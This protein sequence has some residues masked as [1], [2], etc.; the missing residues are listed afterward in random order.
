MQRRRTVEI[1]PRKDHVFV[2]GDQLIVIAEMTIHTNQDTLDPE[3]EI[4]PNALQ[5]SVIQRR[6]LCGWRRDIRDM[7]LLLDT[8]VAPGSELHMFN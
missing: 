3:V 1:N 2:E 8:M 5:I 7:M 6:F 4:I